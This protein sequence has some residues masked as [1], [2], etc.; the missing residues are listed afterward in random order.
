MHISTPLRYPGG[1]TIMSSLFADLFKIND[2]HGVT[3]VEPYAGGAGAAIDLLLHGIVD[4][5]LIND[6]NVAI[7]SFWKAVIEDTDELCEMIYRTNVDL[8]VWRKMKEIMLESKE[9][10]FALGFATFFLSRTN[11][12]GILSA[13]P[14]GGKTEEGQAN[15]KYKIDCRF[16]K[17]DLIEKIQKIGKLRQQV[18]VKYED[19]IQLLMGLKYKKCFVYLDPPYYAKGKSLYMNFYHPRDHELLANYLH[20]TDKFSWVLSYDDVEA[21]RNLYGDMGLYQFSIS[22]TAQDKKTGKELLC[23]SR[24]LIMPT[25][26]VIHRSQNDVEVRK[27]YMQHGR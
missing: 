15:A 26:F 24:D 2:L 25:P 3:Y 13:G 20:K 7:Y 12:S 9:P 6:A 19:A 5:I 1:K 4:R 21:I 18:I 17:K 8:D 16:N 23:H 14:I 27:V 11:R 22:Y 10:C